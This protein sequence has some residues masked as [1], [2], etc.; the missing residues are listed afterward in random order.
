MLP[1]IQYSTPAI[2]RPQ[3]KIEVIQKQL[4]FYNKKAKPLTMQEECEEIINSKNETL[5][6]KKI[7]ELV[8]RN[9]A[10]QV[11]YEKE[12]VARQKLEESLKKAMQDAE[13]NI[14]IL[15]KSIPKNPAPKPD[16]LV[17]ALKPAEKE[18]NGKDDLKT[19]FKEADKK[20]QEQRVKIQ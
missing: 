11:K 8:Q 15:D 2:V 9:K 10:L 12:K 16:P 20:V 3:N 19:K 5:K 18:E 1:S 14:K 7:R 13:E 6:D 4:E 17:K